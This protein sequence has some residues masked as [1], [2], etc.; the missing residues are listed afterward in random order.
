[1]A[2]LCDVYVMD[3]FATAHRAE[4]STHGVGKFAPVACAGPLLVNELDALEKALGNP[5]RPLVAIVGGLEGLDEADRARKP[6]RQ[7]RQADRRRRHREY[8]PGRG[9]P[10]D[11]QVAARGRHDR[12]RAEPAR[13]A[14]APR[15]W[16]IPLPTD[17]VVAKEFAASAEADVKPVAQVAD[18]EMILDI[19]PDT[20][21]RF[22]AR[23]AGRR[24]D[25]L[26][27]PGRRVRVR[28]VRRRH[29]R[30]RAGRLRAARRSRSLAAAT[31]SRPSRNTASRKIFRTSRRR[32]AH[33]SS[34][35]RARPSRPWRCSNSA[36][37][38]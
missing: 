20:A 2:A 10:P 25:R 6:A 18:G 4:A 8:V 23:V 19:G 28:P 33:S 35:S 17:V 13:S 22:A 11:R 16:Q 32:A 31:R 26:E 21:E 15:G 29:A 24:H 5:K 1:M 12:C 37:K 3:A 38:S 14:R 27:R 36:Q 9:R 30:D 34:S 7:G